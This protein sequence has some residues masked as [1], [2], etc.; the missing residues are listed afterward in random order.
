VELTLSADTLTSEM[1]LDPNSGQMKLVG[2]FITYWVF[3]VDPSVDA[4]LLVLTETGKVG[5]LDSPSIQKGNNLGSTDFFEAGLFDLM[6]G[7]E[8]G[9]NELTIGPDPDGDGPLDGEIAFYRRFGAFDPDDPNTGGQVDPV[10]SITFEI[11]GPAGLTVHDFEA[12]SSS[13]GEF[14]PYPNAAKMQGFEGPGGEAAFVNGDLV[15]DADGNNMLDASD[16]DTIFAEIQTPTGNEAADVDGDDDVD[17]DDVGEL[18][19]AYFMTDPGDTDLDGD[20]DIGDFN[21]WRNG[22]LFGPGGWAN[23]DFDGD[24][25]DIGDF[26]EWRNGFLGVSNP[27]PGALSMLVITAAAALGRRRRPQRSM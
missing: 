16:I 2:E 10:E 25:V 18:L 11:T 9:G 23:G 14:G 13:G 17:V 24:G 15:G 19:N 7:F 4:S 3:A 1:V 20:V 6:F 21:N 5:S 27:E 26:N 8:F 12:L 22:F